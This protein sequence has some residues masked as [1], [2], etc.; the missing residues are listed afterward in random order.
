MDAKQTMAQAVPFQHR[1]EATGRVSQQRSTRRIVNVPL[2][3]SSVVTVGVL[4]SIALALHHYQSGKTAATF[5]QRATALEDEQKWPQA[6]GYLGRYLQLE[7]TDLDARLR[8]ISAVEKSATSGPGRYRL[9]SLLYQTLGNLPE[10]NDLRLKLAQQLLDLHDFSG[11]ELEARKLI[12]S[13]DKAQQ[14]TARR[15]IAISLRVQAREGGIV[16]LKQA[17]EALADALSHDPSDVELAS[18]SAEL[19]RQNADE[20][21]PLATPA[22]ADEIMDQLVATNP[23]NVEALVARYKYRQMYGLAGGQADLDAA[24]SIDSDNAEALLLAAAADSSSGDV[25]G[26]K[27]AES[28]LRKVIELE[29]QDPR[30]Y[31]GLGQLHLAAGDQDQAMATLLEG[32]K[33]LTSPNLELDYILSRILIDLHRIDEATTIAAEFDQEFKKW[34]PEFST[35]NRIKVENMNRLLRAQLAFFRN[36]PDEVVRESQA[37]IASMDKAGDKSESVELLDAYSLLATVMTQANRPDL[38]AANWAALADRAPGYRDAGL[39]AGAA[40]LALGRIDEALLQLEGYSKLPIASPEVLNLL[41]QAR[42]QE[43]L[44]RRPNMRD[45]KPFLA[46]VAQTKVRLSDRWEWQ[47]AEVDY[48]ITQGKSKEKSVRQQAALDRLHEIEVAFPTDVALNERLVVYYQRLGRV[49]DAERILNR[50]DTLATS[51]T[52]RATLRAALYAADNRSKDAIRLLTDAASKAAPDA[53][54]ELD[55][56]RMRL[57]IVMGQPELAQEIAAQLIAAAPSDRQ[58][59]IQGIEIA[60]QRGDFAAAD[61]WE[62]ILRQAS[63]V[64]DFDWRYYRARRLLGEFAKLDAEQLRELNQLV[65]TLRSQRPDWPPLMTLG[66]QYAE[67]QGDRPGAIEAYRAAIA[68][69]DRRTQTLEQLVRAL[70]AEGRFDEAN[71]YLSD[72]GSDQNLQGRFESMA[73]ASAVQGN[74]LSEARNLAKQAVDRGSGDSLHYMWLANLQLNDGEQAAAEKTFRT[75]LERFPRDARVWNGLFAYFMQT[76]QQQKARQ[77]LERWTERVPM[78]E[79]DKQLILGQGNEALGDAVAAEKC[80]RAVIELKGDHINAHFRLAKLLLASDT[81]AAREQLEQVL[82]LD[83]NHVE[84]RQYLAAA[85]AA[86]GNEADWTHAEQLLQ[87]SPN[88]PVDEPTFDDDRLHAI[89]LARKGKNKSERLENYEQ[90]RQILKARLDQPGS[91]EATYDVDRMLLASIY[92]QEARLRD[93]PALIESARETLRPLV[94]RTNA[95]ADHLTF[96][97]QLL[98]RHFAQSEDRKSDA[99]SDDTRAIFAEDVRNRIDELEKV[100][101]KEPGG[102]R[103]GVPTALRVKLFALEDRPEEGHK[104]IEQQTNQA[105]AGAADDGARAK[106]YLQAGDLCS[107]AGFHAEAEKW[108]RRLVEIAPNSYV[109]VA[110]SLLEQGKPMEAV[111]FC[112]EKGA[113]LPPASLAMVL[114][115]ILSSEQ[116]NPEMDRKARPVIEAA[117]DADR[118]NVQLLMTV[119]VERVTRNDTEEAAKLFQR[120]IQLQPQNTLALNNLAT[121]FAEQPDRLE[122]AQQYVERAIVVAGRNPALL[123]TLGTILV[124]SGKYSEAVAALEE[125]VAGTASDPRYYFHLAAAYAGAGRDA[126]AQQALQTAT[127]LGLDK[128]LLTTGDREMLASLKHELLTAT[129]RD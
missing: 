40:D 22:H 47:L 33:K 44:I 21:G 93:D 83:P 28:K 60:L 109:L 87:R 122:E 113:K 77:V 30:G 82:R 91:A 36:K 88:S 34:L 94:D 116:I 126:D 26:R 95:S 67:C 74:R 18:L 10:R 102:K 62:G 42:L 20:V 5:L 51:S 54:R 110:Q 79:A 1:P 11:A 80:Y 9:V 45:W 32:R 49:A 57:L 27:S 103:R 59:L 119:A 17:A 114:A 31:I 3:I 106:I 73:I 61:K 89:L 118:G 99:K 25:A 70:Y 7:P 46:A 75:A 41:V 68:A 6:A 12:D 107:S 111:D 84:A 72:A 90:A 123:D 128:A 112:L 35:A 56:A 78:E 85:L 96:Y 55:T 92:E 15:I 37:I 105:L 50:Y 81:Q 124:R 19:Y 76:Q 13:S 121:L 129:L 8:L 66:G 64:D 101:E 69:G 127:D 2:L 97:I 48:L 71:R 117:L 115:H 23:Q 38:A 4:G 14:Q 24:L 100:I 39:K 104:L 125:A 29:P 65:E 43:Q 53:R 16:G 86:T 63:A 58:L 120:V 52:R 108:Y 98:M